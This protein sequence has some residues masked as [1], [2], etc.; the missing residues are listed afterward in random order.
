MVR[1]E[2]V[3]TTVFADTVPHTEMMVQE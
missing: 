3:A 1:P 2:L